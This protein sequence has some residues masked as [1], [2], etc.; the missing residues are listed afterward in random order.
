MCFMRYIIITI[1]LVMAAVMGCKKSDLT[2]YDSTPGVYFDLFGAQRDSL[3]YTFADAPELVED[4]F[5]L[6][7]RLEGI[8]TDED[9]SF[10]LRTDPDST[11]AEVGK[12]YEA[13]KPS[14]TIKAGEGVFYVPVVLYNTDPLLQ[15]A[16]VKI[17]FVL[18]PTDQLGIT[19]GTRLTV[20]RLVFSSKLERPAWWTQWLQDYYSQVKHQL[21]ILV[22]GQTSLSYVTPD[23]PQAGL[24]APKNLFFVG[25]LN[26]F[27]A[28]PAKWVENNPEKG[29]V[30]E[31]IDDQTYHFYN[32]EAPEKFIVYKYDPVALAF[33]FID[34]NGNQVH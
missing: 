32:P 22:T 26:S 23:N 15:E 2:L 29:Y 3:I 13:L 11:T 20:A 9:R 14:Y 34:E 5:Y 18:E 31:K 25:L 16:S 19:M 7:V 10:V 28:N 21:F 6:P 4:T 17:K 8:R 27:L 33:Y 24:D 12:H 30:L 1:L